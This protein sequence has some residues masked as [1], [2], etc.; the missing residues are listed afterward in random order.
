MP[1]VLP[2]QQSRRL[3]HPT[4][5]CVPCRVPELRPYWPASARHLHQAA[6]EADWLLAV[7]VV[8][9][10]LPA[11]R[12]APP[13]QGSGAGRAPPGTC[14]RSHAD[15]RP[16]TRQPDPAAGHNQRRPRRASHHDQSLLRTG[17][18]AR[19][20]SRSSVRR[21]RDS[22][23]R[24]ARWPRSRSPAAKPQCHGMCGNHPYPNPAGSLTPQ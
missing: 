13:W 9:A 1:F 5:P 11:R 14:A 20:G 17:P 19:V 15:P 2:L 6:Q 10:M 16:G 7:Q 4:S 8:A 23:K 21:S 24:I 22:L 18:L 3:V 12:E